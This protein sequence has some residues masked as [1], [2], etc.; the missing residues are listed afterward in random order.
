MRHVQ[1]RIL[2]EAQP[3]LGHGILALA[4]REERREMELV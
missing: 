4:V 3:G 2:G 1:C